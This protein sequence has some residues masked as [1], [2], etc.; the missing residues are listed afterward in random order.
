MP[1]RSLE[2]GCTVLQT[3]YCTASCWKQSKTLWLLSCA[4]PSLNGV[5]NTS[6]NYSELR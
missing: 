5:V 3:N 2:I 6:F 4:I 1:Y